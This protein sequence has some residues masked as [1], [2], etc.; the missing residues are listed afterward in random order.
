MGR[1]GRPTGAEAGGEAAPPPEQRPPGAVSL[2]HHSGWFNRRRPVAGWLA[3]GGRGERG[4]KKKRKEGEASE[5]V[6][7]RDH[8]GVPGGEGRERERGTVEQAALRGGLAQAG[9]APPQLSRV[10]ASSRRGWVG[11][12]EEEGGRA[13]R[14][15]DERR[16]EAGRKK[17]EKEDRA[18]CSRGEREEELHNSSM[19][20]DVTEDSGAERGQERSPSR[21]ETKG[22]CD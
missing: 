3:G 17:T 21:E 12:R 13:G 10:R 9:E 22:G 19:R 5:T 16:R 15:G 7:R 1:L 4:K 14:G 20:Y 2:I 18:S 8:S 6:T 11:G